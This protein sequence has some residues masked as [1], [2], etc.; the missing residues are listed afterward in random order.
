MRVL[1]KTLGFL[2][3]INSVI[4]MIKQSVTTQGM[5]KTEKCQS[6]CEVLYWSESALL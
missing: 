1:I 5:Y 3:G 2:T 4:G 6:K